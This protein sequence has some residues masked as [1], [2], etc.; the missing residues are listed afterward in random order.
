MKL[1]QGFVSN[2]SSSSFI[3]DVCGE[4]VEGRDLCLDEAEMYRCVN[5]HTFCES[6][7]LGE[8]EENSE[9]EDGWDGDNYNIPEKNCPICNFVEASNSDIGK[10]FE[11]IYGITRE[12]VFEEVKK[13]N[14]RRKKLRDYEYVE[15]VCRTKEINMQ[16]LLVDLKSRFKDYASF[17]ESF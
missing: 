10:Y 1:R 4:T 2:S 9:D 13:I 11:K 15:Y 7:A 14:K 3:C 8:V 6:E 16:D 5:E 17:L 12:S